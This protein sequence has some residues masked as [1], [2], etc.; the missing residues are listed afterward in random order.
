M[1]SLEMTWIRRPQGAC[2][3]GDCF[4]VNTI[5]WRNETTPNIG[6]RLIRAWC[7]SG[8]S[9]TAAAPRSVSAQAQDTGSILDSVTEEANRL[10]GTLGPQ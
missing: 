1:P 6:R 5:S 9:A 8:C 3:S 10:A 7:S 2:D 4:Y